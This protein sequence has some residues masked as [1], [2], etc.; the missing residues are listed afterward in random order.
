MEK[1]CQGKTCKNW[2]ICRLDNLKY[3]K[4]LSGLKI[5]RFKRFERPEDMNGVWYIYSMACAPTVSANI[6]TLRVH[7]HSWNPVS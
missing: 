6:D 1:G 5:R 3:L 4:I 2:K 7:L